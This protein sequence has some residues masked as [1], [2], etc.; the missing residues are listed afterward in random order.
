MALTDGKL[1]AIAANWLYGGS[2]TWNGVSVDMREIP[3]APM[4]GASA[5]CHL[6][7]N[8]AGGGAGANVRVGKS[9]TLFAGLTAFRLGADGGLRPS[10]D[11]LDYD[12]SED[13]ETGGGNDGGKSVVASDYLFAHLY[14]EYRAGGFRTVA[15]AAV[16][17]GQKNLAPAL[18]FRLNYR[19]KGSSAEYHIVSYPANFAAPMSRLKKQLSTEIGERGP[20]SM[21]I[22]KHALRTAVP[23]ADGA[24]KLAAASKESAGRLKRGR[25]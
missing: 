2:N 19:V 1:S 17:I 6:R 9:S 4:V 18:S 12:A 13:G 15:E 21:Y 25:A 3:A 8:E 11:S 23:F 7:P 20:S 5:F 14:A 10:R 16:P 24:V 22:R